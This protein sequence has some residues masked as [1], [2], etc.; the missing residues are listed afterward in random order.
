[1]S[2]S[3]GPVGLRRMATWRDPGGARRFPALRG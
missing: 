2:T 3:M 1:L